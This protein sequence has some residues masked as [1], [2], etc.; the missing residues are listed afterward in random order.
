MTIEALE[1]ELK[2]GQLQSLYLLYGEELYLV[3][4]NLKKIRNQI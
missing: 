3:E 2:S 4:S 1:K